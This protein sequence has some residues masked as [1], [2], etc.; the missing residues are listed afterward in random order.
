MYINPF[1]LGV[2]VGVLITLAAIVLLAGINTGKGD[3]Q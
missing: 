2:L 3:D 1:W